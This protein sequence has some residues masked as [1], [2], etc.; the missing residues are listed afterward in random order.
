[1]T[2]A[3]RRILRSFGD[4]AALY[5]EQRRNA[6]HANTSQ[7]GVRDLET[8][9]HRSNPAAMSGTYTAATIM[10]LGNWRYRGR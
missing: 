2:Q 1:M 6:H 7:R 8:D 5:R 10:Q 4:H 9:T 3:Y